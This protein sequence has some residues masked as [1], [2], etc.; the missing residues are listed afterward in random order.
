M[1]FVEVYFWCVMYLST[2]LLVSLVV[3]LL[4]GWGDLVGITII[5]LLLT[6]TLALILVWQDKR[7]EREFECMEPAEIVS[8]IQLFFENQELLEVN[9]NAEEEKTRT[10]ST[11][12]ANRG[13]G[14]EIRTDV[15]LSELSAPDDD[16]AC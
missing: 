10:K 3:N 12:P 4:T 2:Y 7:E 6:F 13:G 9:T 15:R 1:R 5:G 14:S 8:P 11:D 16:P